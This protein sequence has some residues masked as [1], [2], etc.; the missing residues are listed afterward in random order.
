MLCHGF[1]EMGDSVH[2]LKG[3]A[4]TLPGVRPHAAELY[5]RL[6]IS[7]CYLLVPNGKWG[8]E[9]R[10]RDRGMYGDS[11][12]AITGNRSPSVP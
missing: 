3:V 4:Q 5:L 2:W 1:W 7:G 9:Y 11:I 10:C 8:S 6:T 12:G